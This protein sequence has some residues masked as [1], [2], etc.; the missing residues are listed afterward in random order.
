MPSYQNIFVRSPYVVTINEPFQIETQ[1]KI[2]IWNVG[3]TPPASPAY[4][5]SK[6]IPASNAPSTYYNVAPYIQEYIKHLIPPSPFGVSSTPSTEYAKVMIKRFKKI[7]NSFIQVGTDSYYRAFDGFGEF[8]DGANPDLGRFSLNQALHFDY[9]TDQPYASMT[10]VGNA[11][12]EIQWIDLISGFSQSATINSDGVYDLELVNSAWQYSGNE[13]TIKDSLGNLLWNTYMHPRTECKYEHIKC[14]FINQWGAWQTTWFYARTTESFSTQTNGYNLMLENE[15]VNAFNYNPAKGETKTFNT[16]GKRTFK[17][18][19]GWV[20][21]AYNE[22][23]RELMLSER[24]VFNNKHS[25]KLITNSVEMYKAID[26][27][28]MN[29][30]LDFEDAYDYLNYNI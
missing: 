18:N 5:L 26:T 6:K 29:F 28:T 7:S 11:G 8:T 15:D 17:V 22:V 9:D 13:V 16:N 1:I 30:T 4:T 24:V 25:V 27:K 10:F 2:Y 21:E 20:D 23:I 3:N 12:D 19:T 14:S